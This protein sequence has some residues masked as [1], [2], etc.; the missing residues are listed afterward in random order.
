MKKISLLIAIVIGSL[1]LS[2]ISSAQPDNQGKARSYYFSAE[3]KFAQK[4][5]VNT[6]MY[7]QSAENMLGRSNARIEALRA[8]A[9][10]QKG[11]I[12]G[13]KRTLDRFFKYSPNASLTKEM[14]G[15]AR[16]IEARYEANKTRIAANR[17]A[18]AEK[19]R[20]ARAAA[21]ERA[22]KQAAADQFQQQRKS[23]ASKQTRRLRG[24]IEEVSREC[25][26]AEECLTL[27]TQLLAISEQMD[28]DIATF[29]RAYPGVS[30]QHLVHKLF[31]NREKERVIAEKSC[32]LG[33][34]AGCVNFDE[35]ILGAVRIQY[36]VYSEWSDAIKAQAELLTGVPCPIDSLFS[37]CAFKIRELY[38]GKGCDLKHIDACTKLRGE[39][40]NRRMKAVKGTKLYNIAAKACGFGDKDS[41]WRVYYDLYQAAG[42]KWT[43]DAIKF[44]DLAC[45][46]G[47]EDTCM[48]LAR[49]I[50]HGSFNMKKNKK[51][52]R[53]YINKFCA[54]E[55]LSEKQCK[56][57]YRK[58]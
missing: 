28:K 43:N 10:H 8:K 40:A 33:S 15:Y 27:S 25:N 17:R 13:A 31:D 11:D 22:R 38:L 29:A 58:L 4:D 34:G 51:L 47:R 2:S 14:A 1:F 5:Y 45:T 7:L 56:K 57:E 26:T 6:L 18:K 53:A 12:E 32:S 21:E 44:A 48:Y 41:C 35:A 37:N 23:N 16:E 50:R 54:I 30:H 52:A 24:Q 39:Y 42:R 3:E 19:A 46:H 20:E 55:G 36:R 49:S 9:L